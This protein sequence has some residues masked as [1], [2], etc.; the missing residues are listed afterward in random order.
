[1]LDLRTRESKR[2]ANAPQSA[3]RELVQMTVC[4]DPEYHPVIRLDKRRLL[5]A[6][7]RRL[8]KNCEE[9]RS[10][11]SPNIIRRLENM[12]ASEKYPDRSDSHGCGLQI[13]P[14]A[15]E[16]HRVSKDVKI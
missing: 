4:D 7:I 8:W 2:V 10:R 6:I 3:S 14:I 11:I 16:D 1:V 9:T 13:A 15:I 5:S 12:R